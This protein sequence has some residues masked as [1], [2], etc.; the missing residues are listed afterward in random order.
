MADAAK[1]KRTPK[2]HL[3]DDQTREAAWDELA[4]LLIRG[5]THQQAGDALG[6]HKSTIDKWCL[7][8]AFKLKLLRTRQ[9]LLNPP[10]DVTANAVVEDIRETIKSY[11]KDAIHKMYVIM[12]TADHDR[13]QLKAAQELADRSPET[14]KTRGVLVQGSIA[15]FSAEDLVIMAQTAAEVRQDQA[16]GRRVLA[17]ALDDSLALPIE[18]EPIVDNR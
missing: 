2:K 8:E 7:S 9:A 13:T 15:L 18:V 12:N 5:A 10:K 14:Q 3:I 16:V 11:A 17:A 1:S 6:F 4:R